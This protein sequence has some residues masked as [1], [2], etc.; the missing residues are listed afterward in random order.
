MIPPSSAAKVIIPNAPLECKTAVAAIPINQNIRRLMSLYFPRSNM[1][2]N[3]STLSFMKLIHRKRSQNP[4]S[5]CAIVLYFSCFT[6]INEHQPNA[7]N[8]MA[9]TEILSSQKPRKAM[10]TAHVADQIFAPNITPIALYNCITP[11]PTNAIVSNV[12]NVL[13]FSNDVAVNPVVS[14]AHLLLVYFSRNHFTLFPQSI[15]SACSKRFIPKMINHNHARNHR[16][17]TQ[18]MVRELINKK[19]K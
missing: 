2:C 7:I 16:I 4:I 6:K 12:T 17:S 1:A 3:A 14:D 15:F 9:M 18:P 11:A 5:I 8:G 19:E 13:L 10:S